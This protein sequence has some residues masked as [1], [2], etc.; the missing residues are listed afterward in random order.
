MYY[1]GILS[2]KYRTNGKNLLQTKK[3][4]L[5][6]SEVGFIVFWSYED[7]PTR[8]LGLLYLAK[9]VL[10]HGNRSTFAL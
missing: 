8:H 5:E 4:I 10:L 6:I 3:L 1:R 2:Y 7:I 9:V